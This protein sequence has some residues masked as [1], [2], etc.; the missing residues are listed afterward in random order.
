M[1]VVNRV[2]HFRSKEL[3]KMVNRLKNITLHPLT[4]FMVDDMVYKLLIGSPI[5]IA[6]EIYIEEVYNSK[7]K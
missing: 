1:D 4:K 5:S 6:D 2:V 3:N 7:F